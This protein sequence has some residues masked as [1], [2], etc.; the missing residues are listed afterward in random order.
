MI[1]F[2]STSCSCSLPHCACDCTDCSES[3]P[4]SAE[5]SL[6]SE[7]KLVL[8]PPYSASPSMTDHIIRQSLPNFVTDSISNSISINSS[9]DSEWRSGLHH[10]LSDSRRLANTDTVLSLQRGALPGVIGSRRMTQVKSLSSKENDPSVR[11]SLSIVEDYS[12]PDESFSEQYDYSSTKLDD[13]LPEYYSEDE[14]FPITQNPDP[15]K[16]HRSSR[17]NQVPAFPS[18]I[19]EVSD[20]HSVEH[21]YSSTGDEI[22]NSILESQTSG[23]K[24]ISIIRP[25]RRRYL[26]N[27]RRNLNRHNIRS[28]LSLPPPPPKPPNTYFKSLSFTS[29]R[30]YSSADD[31]TSSAAN[32]SNEPSLDSDSGCDDHSFTSRRPRCSRGCCLGSSGESPS[33]MRSYSCKSN[34]PKAT[35]SNQN[36]LKTR[37]SKSTSSKS[38]SYY[39]SSNESGSR[40][41][42]SD[43]HHDLRGY[44]IGGSS[45]VQNWSNKNKTSADI[46]EILSSFSLKNG[47]RIWNS[48]K[49]IRSSIPVLTPRKKR[50][51]MDD[52]FLDT[53]GSSW[54]EFLKELETPA[55]NCSP[56]PIF[57]QSTYEAVARKVSGMISSGGSAIVRSTKECI[58]LELSDVHQY[59]ILQS[60]KVRHF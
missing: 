11:N 33:P 2:N 16:Q 1:S 55:K 17:R 46:S 47:S 27:I 28:K 49:T 59:N 50:P 43:T 4:Y 7:D 19:T 44:T 54:I 40:I 20:E 29:E 15:P 23:T 10:I 60:L 8:P 13:F 48:R 51:L 6:F 56:S 25:M 31:Y 41:I 30:E 14:S 5:R 24:P 57:Q 52:L 42:K 35:Q 36:A 9:S 3:L 34:A 26:R 22:S 39:S 45:L 12:G 37:S 53:E 58:P 32:D 21:S 38:T 18:P